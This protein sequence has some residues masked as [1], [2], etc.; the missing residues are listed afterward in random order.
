MLTTDVAIAARN[1]K[2]HTKRNLYLGGALALVTMLLV[3][4][5]GLA[6]G[7]RATMLESASILLSGHVN[8]GGFYKVTSGMA[9]PLVTDFE[10]VLAETKK[11][12][13]ELDFATARGRGYA[14]AVSGSATMDLILGGID[15][16]REKGFRRVI[17]AVSGSLDELTKPGTILIFADQAKRLDLAVGDM[18]T[19]SAPTERGMYN[20]ADLRV[21]AIAKNIGMLSSMS[22]FVPNA[23]LLDLYQ[24]KPGTTGALHLYL[25]DPAAAP[26]VAARLRTAL[27]AAGWRVMDADPQPYWMKLMNKVTLEDWIGQKLDVTTWEDEMSFVKW[28]LAAVSG[29]T[30]LLISILMV[31]VVI[32]IMNTMWIAIRERTREIGTLRAIGMQRRRVL[33]LFVLEAALLAVCGTAAGALGGWLVASLI[34]AAHIVMPEN[35]RVFLMSQELSLVVRPSS[36]VVDILVIAGVTTLAALYPARRAAGLRPITAIHHIG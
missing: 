25:H 1:L 32:G 2:Q 27:A 28:L 3:L 7:I 17:E 33:G 29:L 24:L 14:R 12:V 6:D 9:A 35:V 23:A 8:V 15:I 11:N 31:I 30:G 36:L 5:N 4:L 21:A 26:A 16:E 13:P 19:L 34:N 10:K 22:A 18:L 20:T